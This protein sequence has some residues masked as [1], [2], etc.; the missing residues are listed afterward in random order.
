[1]D[2]FEE[3]EDENRNLAKSFIGL[4]TKKLSAELIEMR[5]AGVDAEEEDVQEMIGLLHGLNL[6]VV[7][8]EL[9]EAMKKSMEE[10]IT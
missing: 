8:Q 3:R 7:E 9:G 1:M 2:W 4:V 5:D 10:A 6:I